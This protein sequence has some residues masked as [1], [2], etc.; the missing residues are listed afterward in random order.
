MNVQPW[1]ELTEGDTGYAV[2]G[3]QYLLRQHG[4]GIA[5]DGSYGPLTAAAVAEFQAAAGLPEAGFVGPIT[6][7]QL[8]VTTG[9][10][11]TGEAGRGIQSCGLSLIPESEPLVVD[12]DYG[13]VTESRV[14]LFQQLWGLTSDGLA[15]RETWSYLT[16]DRHTLWPLVKPGDTG[17]RVLPVQYL[18]RE[19]GFDIAADGV[20]GPITGEAVR[21]FDAANRGV[22]VSDVVGNLTWPTLIVQVGPGDTGEAVRALQSV[23][24]VLT[25]DGDF[26]PKT[27]A[28]VVDFQQMFG[29]A[30]DGIAGPETWHTLMVPK[31]E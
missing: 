20:Y 5:P 16:A 4:S 25:V 12:G 7:R 10:G 13:P 22:F 8:V 14:R 11:D 23:F 1:R 31:G 15:G 6:W 26:G 2:T 29:L 27:E 28:A 24:P 17:Y 21:Q 19:R 3:M 18:L 30:V 9:P